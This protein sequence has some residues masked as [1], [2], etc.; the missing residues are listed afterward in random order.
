MTHFPDSSAVFTHR[1][2][3]P[4]PGRGLDAPGNGNSSAAR[5]V[6]GTSYDEPHAWDRIG[7]FAAGVAI[8]IAIGGG[9]SLLLAPR[10]GEDTRTLIR[11]RAQELAER[12]AE[13][14]DR[15]RDDILWRSRQG[16]KAL[17][18]GLIR[19]RWSAEDALEQQRRRLRV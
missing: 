6:V 17:R 4:T 7:F 3:L 14:K 15:I 16:R 10:S 13:R 5:R 19:G 12:M 11:S 2:D 9:V 1:S 18:R 8:G